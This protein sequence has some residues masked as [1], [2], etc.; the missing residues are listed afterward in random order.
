MEPD[1]DKKDPAM[2]RDMEELETIVEKYGGF[3]PEILDRAEGW[4]C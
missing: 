2:D 3:L 1:E 4:F